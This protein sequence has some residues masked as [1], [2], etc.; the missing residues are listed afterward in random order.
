MQNWFGNVRYRARHV[1]RP[2]SVAELQE[3]VRRSPRIRALGTG[4]AC[5]DVAD[6]TGDLVSLADMPRRFEV[7]AAARTVRIDG[8]VR[9]GEL[10]EPLHEAGFAL[11]NMASLPHVSVAGSVATGTHGSG[12]RSGS[13]STAVT[14][15][16]IVGPDG[17]LR[18]VEGDEVDAAVVSLGALG[19]VTAL[20]LRVEPA[21]VMRQDVYEDLPL[22]S[23]AAYYAEISAMADS[24][25]FF[26]T[27]RGPSIDQLWLKR[28]V[29]DGRI[30][31]PGEILGA[32][33]ATRQLHPIPGMP[34]QACT[35][36]LGEP[37]PWHARLP[38]FRM[39]HTPSAGAEL[40][41][42]YFIAREHAVEAFL[43]VDRLRA[44]LAPLVQVSEI[45][46]V[47]AD[48]LWLSPAYR[49]DSAT[50]HFTWRPDEPAVRELLPEIESALAPFE[51]RPHWGKLFTIP[52]EL[53]AARYERLADFVAL[54]GRLDPDG[55][56]RN[57]FTERLVFGGR[58]RQDGP[59]RAGPG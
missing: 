52:L 19:V 17:E 39:D 58:A 6:T 26:P 33:R 1:Y 51:P 55:K 42:E 49:R 11:H 27:W 48:D 28:R 41:S 35:P 46:S 25:S 15:L 2:R 44:R 53:V 31:A 32:R 45:R 22:E 38:H 16:E 37:G 13:L 9:Y 56:C 29:T 30:D 50:I 20:D 12:D 54:T 3:L 10:C 4:H 8:A 23:F 18:I 34:A 43:A 14:R 7:D 5:S 21:Y 57:D 24:V 40:Q 59:G 36:Q 47:A